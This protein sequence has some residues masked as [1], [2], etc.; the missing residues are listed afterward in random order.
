M[1]AGATAIVMTLAAEPCSPTRALISSTP[2]AYAAVSVS[3]LV[4][5][6]IETAR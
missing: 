3:A 4:P 5:A 6:G 1:P 2:S